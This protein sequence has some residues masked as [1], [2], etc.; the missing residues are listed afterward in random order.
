MLGMLVARNA[1]ESMRHGDGKDKLESVAISNNFM[2]S[3]A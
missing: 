1:S 3:A 2:W